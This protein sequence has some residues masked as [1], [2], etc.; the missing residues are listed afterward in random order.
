M[1]WSP[2]Q[3]FRSDT[4]IDTR[5]MAPY[6]KPVISRYLSVNNGISKESS[7]LSYI[8]VDSFARR[9]V[10]QG[11][12]SLLV[13]MDIESAYRIIPV[14]P[15]DRELLGVKWRGKLYVDKALSFGLQSACKIFTSVAD[16]VE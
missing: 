11:R 13:K 8:S 5:K 14:H 9:V 2:H 4:K 15:D 12:R 3:P 6:H 16:A 7:S 10:Q 1:A